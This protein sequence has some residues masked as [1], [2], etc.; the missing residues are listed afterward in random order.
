MGI[1]GSSCAEGESTGP[2]SG[3]RAGGAVEVRP[4][5]SRRELRDFVEI[6]YRL[7]QPFAFRARRSQAEP[8]QGAWVPPLRRDRWAQFDRRRHPFFRFGQAELFVAYRN[9]Q[10][11]G[12]IAAIDN[13]R[14]TERYRD[15]VG[16]FGF[17]ESQRDEQI[18]GELVAS[19]RTWL[20]DRGHTVMRGP[21]NYT[22][23]ETC[24][25]LIEGFEDPPAL[26]MPWNPPFY[27][28][29]L[30]QAG[31]RVVK[32]LVA[33]EVPSETA[34]S[35]EFCRLAERLR[36]RSG[37][38][39][40]GVDMR[41]FDAELALCR[42]IYN[43]AWAENWGFVPATHEEFAFL[44]RQLRPVIVPELA[45]MAEIDARPVGFAITLPDWNQA[46]A[47]TDGRLWPFGWYRLWRASKQITRIRTLAFGVVPAARRRGIDVLLIYETYRRARAM[48]YQRAEQGWLLED[49][50]RMIQ[51]VE[52]IGGRRSKTY[53]LLDFAL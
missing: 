26:E 35:R 42:A 52:K 28:E 39:I 43:E 23:N 20:K 2:A 49:N 19:A 51:A 17:F 9:G 34:F 14:H 27:V 4:V 48:G 6:E 53:V 21:T 46:L 44:A 16:F 30:E 11:V 10:C 40:R 38:V 47:M 41:R 50:W 1:F 33:H 24:G 32:R 18:V 7:N 8:W 22:M 31:G 5:R 37:T 29:L 36:Q 3:Q 15:G 45:L 25:L 12:R 13:P